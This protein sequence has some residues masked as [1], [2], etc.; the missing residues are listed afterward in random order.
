MQGRL[1][2]TIVKKPIEFHVSTKTQKP[3]VYTPGTDPGLAM[4]K[5]TDGVTQAYVSQISNMIAHLFSTYGPD[6]PWPGA[7]THPWA[8][9]FCSYRPSCSWW[10]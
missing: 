7:L 4:N 2:S 6:N 9:G 5:S 10:Q 3:A 1:Y 8:C